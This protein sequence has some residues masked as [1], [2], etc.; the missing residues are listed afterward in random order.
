MELR[1]EMQRQAAS[2]AE[3]YEQLQ[4]QEGALEGEA[5]AIANKVAAEKEVLHT[6]Q[7][8]K[9]EL[10]IMVERLDA[11]LTLYEKKASCAETSQAELERLQLEMEGLQKELSRIDSLQIE[12]DVQNAKLDNIS[13]Q[14]TMLEADLASKNKELSEIAGELESK[15][16][17]A[18]LTA[19]ESEELKGQVE[20]LVE[21]AS[22]LEE[23]VMRKRTAIKS[24]E[25]ELMAVEE[26]M[27][28]FLE[29][30]SVDLKE[31]EI[32]R[33]NLHT[34]LRVLTEQLQET[35]ALADK[36]TAIA[37]EAR[38]VPSPSPSFAYFRVVL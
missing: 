32:E 34:E 11:E 3:L 25:T 16:I 30:A 22:A 29:D 4:M 27:A 5:R 17:L 13:L 14:R 7:E 2:F 36:Q 15:R 35:Q 9:A 21:K 24:L 20:K 1:D 23:E 26:T 19:R 6:L 31:L 33:D 28:R 38:Q 37:D 12:L 10:K 18:D 8:E